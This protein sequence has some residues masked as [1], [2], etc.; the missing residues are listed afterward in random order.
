M[1]GK[2]DLYCVYHP[3]RP[4]KDSEADV[5]SMLGF[6]VHN[7]YVVFQ[8]GDQQSAG[9]P[10]GANCGPLLTNLFFILVSL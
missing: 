10:M 4:H 3:N 9:T 1:V 2:D 7:I 6:L 5:K 8:F